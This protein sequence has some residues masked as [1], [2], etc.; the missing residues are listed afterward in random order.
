MTGTD[1]DDIIIIGSGAG[2]HAPALKPA[3]PRSRL[4]TMLG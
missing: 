1:H 4:Q 3:R 2:G